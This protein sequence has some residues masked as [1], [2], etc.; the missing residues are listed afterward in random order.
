[1]KKSFLFF[2]LS[3]HIA[4]AQW[5]SIGPGGEAL[6]SVSFRTATDGW[7]CGANGALFRTSNGG[8]TWQSVINFQTTG[9][10]NRLI[11]VST[12]L[13]Y[14]VAVLTQQPSLLL[15]T[16]VFYSERN[17]NDFQ[18]AFP[19]TVA[20]D[21]FVFMSSHTDKL[22]LLVGLGGSMRLSPA[23]GAVWTQIPRGTQNDLWGADSPDGA[24]YYLVGSKGTIRKGTYPGGV[25]QALNST[26]FTRLTGVWFVTPQQGYVVGDGGMA[27]HTTDA[28]Q[29]W[30]HMVVNTSVNLNAVRF[31]DATTGFIIG[32][33]GTLLMTHDGGATWQPESSNTYETLNGIYASPDGLNTWV[34]GGN[35]TVLKRGASVA[36]ANQFAS[37][38]A[39]WQ[40][41]PS[42]FTTTL[43]LTGLAA[44]LTAREVILIDELGRAVFRHTLDPSAIS[45]AEYPLPLPAT[46]AP[47][48][49]SLQLATL[50][51]A[52]ETRRVVR[53]PE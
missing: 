4:S 47:G 16:Q 13:Q 25:S 52:L 11:S 49:Y 35:G 46:L 6:S 41:Y 12:L 2:I 32:D 8:A 51:Q 26:V 39:R 28:G 42:P 37:V 29:T 43:T 45:P 19:A 44:C 24:T 21:D 30:M 18:P 50:G 23:Q 20:S 48:V 7:I 53:L 38:P 5:T 15:P 17:G 31:L 10:H 3:S 34:V 27:L 22:S 40:V 1:M 36:L 33:L 9:T 14:N